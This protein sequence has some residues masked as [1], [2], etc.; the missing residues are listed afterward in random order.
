MWGSRIFKEAQ[1]AEKR[2]WFRGTRRR[3]DRRRER[4]NMLQSLIIEDMEKQYPNF[5]PM[6]RETS[7]D[8]EDKNISEK[9]LGKKYNL[10]SDEKET[11]I[12]YYQKFKTIYHLRK[13]LINTNEKVDIRLV[14][15]AMHHI[16]KYRGN[17]LYEG[18]FSE[19]SN[20][21]IEKVEEIIKFLDNR[22]EITLNTNKE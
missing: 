12:D 7:F 5:F 4:I 13:H 14:Y 22:Y 17:F 15:L 10:F 18:D 20:E 16:I 6:L 8:Y 2:R 21:I 9:I 1:T 3:I 19:N 11:D